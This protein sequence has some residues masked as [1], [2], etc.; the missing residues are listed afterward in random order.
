MYRVTFLVDNSSYCKY[1]NF[2]LEAF[3]DFVDHNKLKDITYKNGTRK[4]WL[5]KTAYKFG[6]YLL[7]NLSSE[8]TPMKVD[9]LK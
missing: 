6:S 3:N 9:K 1:K 2:A 8:G 4:V 7:N 5:T